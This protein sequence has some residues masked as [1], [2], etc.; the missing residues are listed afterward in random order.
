LVYFIDQLIDPIAMFVP[1][2]VDL[3]FDARLCGCKVYHSWALGRRDVVGVFVKSGVN[4]REAAVAHRVDDLVN[5]LGAQASR[6]VLLCEVGLLGLPGVGV[7][8]LQL[9]AGDRQRL[10]VGDLLELLGGHISHLVLD[11]QHSLG[12][13]TLR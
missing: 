10:L 3:D 8:R 1:P 2:V 13:V 11:M 4:P 6:S 12:V 7:E 5:Q 9:D